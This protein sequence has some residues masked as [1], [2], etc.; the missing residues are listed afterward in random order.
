MPQKLQNNSGIRASC[1]NCDFITEKERCKIVRI[2]SEFDV[3][4]LAKRLE[5]Q[6]QAGN[7]EICRYY[8]P[9]ESLKN[10]IDYSII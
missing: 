8:Q 10:Q 6:R 3:N 1:E 9:T 2:Y 5:E 4:P 7:V